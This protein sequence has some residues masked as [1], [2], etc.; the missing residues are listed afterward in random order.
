MVSIVADWWGQILHE[1][2]EISAAG[3]ALLLRGILRR[4]NESVQFD[5]LPS[6]Y[7]LKIFPSLLVLFL[8]KMHLCI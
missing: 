3:L 1:G 8:V 2:G 5:T 6:L 7:K 4:E